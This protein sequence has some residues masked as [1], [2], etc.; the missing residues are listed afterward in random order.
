MKSSS[1]GSAA[2]GRRHKIVTRIARRPV[3]EADRDLI[4][5]LY[6]ST[7]AAEM[8]MVPWNE[9]QKRAFVE[10]QFAAQCRGYRESFPNAVHEVLSH[11]GRDIGRLYVS[12]ESERIHILDITVA[13]EARDT[14]IGTRVMEDLIEEAQGLPLSIYTESFNP[15]RRLFERLGFQVASEDGFLLLFLR[16]G[17]ESDSSP[18]AEPSGG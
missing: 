6:A 17:K 14:G 12:H 5:R 4:F 1:T 9:D 2:R 3:T 16:A 13:P 11:Q 8:A 18:E 10:S 7:R 15:S